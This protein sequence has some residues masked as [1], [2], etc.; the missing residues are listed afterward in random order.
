MASKREDVIK[1][2]N[3]VFPKLEMRNTE[4]FDGTTNGIWVSGTEDDI[5][6][7]DEFPLFNYWAEDYQEK[8]YVFGVHKEIREIVEDM[9][10]FFEWQD[11]GTAMIW[12]A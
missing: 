9:G 8:R 5:T 7:S 6:A 11:A 4:E 10:W 12:V 1:A 3:K 2:I